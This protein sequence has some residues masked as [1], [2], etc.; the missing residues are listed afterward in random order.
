MMK[1]RISGKT[2]FF[3]FLGLAALALAAFLVINNMNKK[4]A[5]TANLQT[6]EVTRG[7]L[8][9]VIGATGTVRANQSAVL[10]WQ[11][12]GRV[13]SIN[14][15]VGDKVAGETIL[16]E[17]SQ[18]SLSQS[19]ILAQADLVEAERYLDNLLHSN[20][21]SAQA[22]LNLANAKDAY[23][24]AVW[25]SFQGDTARTTNQNKI[26][27]AQAAVTLARDKVNTAE[28][29]FEKVDD[30]DEDDPLRAGALSTLA[31]AR[32]N[33][34]KA[35]RDLNY[36]V[37]NPDAKELAISDGKVALTR[38]QYED[39]QREW[40][41]LKDGPD[42]DDIAAAEAR[43]AAIKA[44][45]GLSH[46]AAP[47]GG[48]VTEVSAMVGDQV[49]G[50]QGAFRLDDLS[51]LLVD[52]QVPEIDINRI[53]VGQNVELVFDAINNKAYQAR[54]HSV[55]QVGTI[56]N[57]LVNFKV[58][59]EILNPDGQVLPGMTAAVSIIISQL[60][61][62]LTIPNRAIRLVDNKS[63]VYVLENG[64]PTPV[65]IVI[66]SSSDTMSEVVSG[67]LKEGDKVILNPPSS[68]LNIHFGE[69]RPF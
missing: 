65:E 9:A 41:R 40:E 28:E 57:G 50:G 14:V 61:D 55:A 17:L 19:I 69:G 51:R 47:F 58:T 25:S 34:E 48:T 1:K 10:N 60:D 2:Y 42:P 68:F 63:V 8:I 18:T 66:G 6:V 30:R 22:Q 12:G 64:A 43:I 11:T 36:L 29:N 39:A 7:E 5:A 3:I 13:G 62:V 49:S 23:D 32:E 4:N 24:R 53:L 21:Q 45:I 52:V 20:L 56:Q 26:D 33:L 16:A 15:E 59:I 44:T 31:N 54:V 27:A 37:Q 35:K 67:G 46:I 38:A